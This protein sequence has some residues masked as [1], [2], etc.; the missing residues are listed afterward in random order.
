[1]LKTSGFWLGYQLGFSVRTVQERTTLGAA[2]AAEEG[3][4]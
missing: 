3:E 1:M 2:A 4:K